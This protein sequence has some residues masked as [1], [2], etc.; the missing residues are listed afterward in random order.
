M[1]KYKIKYAINKIAYNEHIEE[2]SIPKALAVFLEQYEPGAEL[3]SIA[4]EKKPEHR[5]DICNCI[6][7]GY[8]IPN[9]WMSFNVGHN[10]WAND[11]VDSIESYTLCSAKC[12]IDS[13]V[14]FLKE[15][16]EHKTTAYLDDMTYKFVKDFVELFQFKPPI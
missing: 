11:S 12:Y 1:K 4:E 7:E 6:H 15:F 16:E 5:C 14:V 10:D 2:E 9:D 13:M 8:N 3:I